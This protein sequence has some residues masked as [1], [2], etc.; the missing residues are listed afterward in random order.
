MFNTLSFKIAFSY[1][2]VIV[3]TSIIGFA[4]L[5]VSI[6]RF[7]HTQIDDELQDDIDEYLG[8]IEMESRDAALHYFDDDFKS[9]DPSEMLFRWYVNGQSIYSFYDDSVWQMSVIDGFLSTDDSQGDHQIET[10]HFVESGH[11]AKIISSRGPNGVVIQIGFI[12][13]DQLALLNFI[14]FLSIVIVS[15]I[16]L[17]GIIV[18]RSISHY[19]VKGINDV[20]NTANHISQGRFE[21]RVPVSQYGIELESLGKAFNRMADANQQLMNEMKEVNDNIAHD[22]RSPLARMRGLAEQ[23][24]CHENVSD[25]CAAICEDVIEECDILLH[26]INTMLDISELE[27]NLETLESESFDINQIVSIAAECFAPVAEDKKIRLHTKVNGAVQVYGNRRMIQRSIANLV[28]NAVKYTR[29]GGEIWIELVQRSNECVVMVKD[30][31][32]GISDDDREKIFQRFYRGS[33]SRA[34]P[35]NGLGLSLALS[36]ARAH[37]GKLE[38]ASTPDVGSEFYFTLP[39]Q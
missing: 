5:N 20:T 24:I 17:A 25:D 11:T 13:D 31:G 27:S 28:D 12:I 36:V 19:A 21:Q 7:I 4:L 1:A 2:V 6:A 39:I 9:D 29:P 14:Q 32:I 30:T 26:I 35:G 33:K 38:V 22:L 37:S 18:G 34:Q 15:C 23:W 8:I 3:F 16:I 10:I